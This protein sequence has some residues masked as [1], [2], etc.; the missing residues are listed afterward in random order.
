M[1]KVNVIRFYI[2]WPI[3]SFDDMTHGESLVSSNVTTRQF[4]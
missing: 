3:L 1:Y 4:A 2:N